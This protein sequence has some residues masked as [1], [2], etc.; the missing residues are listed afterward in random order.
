MC[1]ILT[2]TSNDE[3]MPG[4]QSAENEDEDEDKSNADM[5]EDEDEESWFTQ[6]EDEILPQESEE[7]VEIDM[8]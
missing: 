4:S 2:D 6:N 1:T 5:D 7:D 8:D 3:D